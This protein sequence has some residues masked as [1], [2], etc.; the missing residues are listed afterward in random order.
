ME[1]RFGH[2]FSN[3]R[4]H[5][6][7]KAAESARAVNALAYTVGRDVV[8]GPGYTPGNVG[9]NRLLAHELAHVVQQGGRAFE[10]GN[11]L[12][13]AASDD[14]LERQAASLSGDSY[15]WANCPASS[16][17]V[18]GFL[19]RAI[20]DAGHQ[21][22]LEGESENKCAGWFS[23]RESTSKRAAEHYVRTELGGD[24]GSVERI[25]CDLFDPSTG[26]FAC[27]VYFTDGTPIRVIVRKDAII[28]GVHPLQSMYPPPDR[29][30]CWY[31]YNCSGPNRDLVLTKRKCQTS[32]TARGAPPSR[33]H[34]PEL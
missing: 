11:V 3:V 34:G 13:L 29:P 24:R 6:D 17:Q 1:P 21:M 23:D 8:F 2:D 7:A 32:G 18:T 22:T 30:L 25:E 28:V 26:A 14:A 12:R 31:D 9:G 19:Q 27:T 10:H 4:V 15:I 20:G 16:P 5:T 33:A